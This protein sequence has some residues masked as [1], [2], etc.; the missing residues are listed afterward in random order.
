MCIF[1]MS[2]WTNKAGDSAGWTGSFSEA[3]CEQSGDAHSGSKEAGVEFESRE[4]GEKEEGE[5]DGGNALTR[6][7][8]AMV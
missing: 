8:H 1:H 2:P 3:L 4:R 6:L 7:N 5:R